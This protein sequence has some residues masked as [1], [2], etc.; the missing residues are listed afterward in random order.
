MLR[1]LSILPLLLMI[2]LSTAAPALA[3]TPPVGGL[4]R[5]SMV[6]Y[7]A[8]APLVLEGTVFEIIED[9]ANWADVSARIQVDSYYKGSGPAEIEVQGYGD[10]A[11][12]RSPI[13]A[14]DHYI[15]FVAGNADGYH[16]V[17]A[18][19]FDAYARA[20]DDSR[21]A[22]IAAVDQEPAPPQAT[23]DSS[24]TLPLLL[25]GSAGLLAV[26]LLYWFRCG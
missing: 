8:N 20:N 7:V 23:G 25:V 15:F 14:G 5:L 24:Q 21:A 3:C 26:G 16:A 11:L 22:V 19:Q 2:S 9:P 12:C 4:P 6:D 13:F 1:R 18:S 17:Y 10:T